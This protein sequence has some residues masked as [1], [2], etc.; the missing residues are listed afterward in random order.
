MDNLM[1]KNLQPESEADRQLDQTLAALNAV[2]PPARLEQ[3]VHARL[4][5]EMRTPQQ[6][7]YR[8]ALAA[9]WTWPRAAFAATAFAAGVATATF[10]LPNLRPAAYHGAPAAPATSV[11]GSGGSTQPSGMPAPA[12]VK[13]SDVHPAFTARPGGRVAAVNAAGTVASARSLKQH[14]DTQLAANK[15]QRKSSEAKLTKPTAP[16]SGSTEQA[17]PAGTAQPENQ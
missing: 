6:Q 4:A 9:A 7:G 1:G 12:V 14:S 8:A 3:R 15:A 11:A 2:V 10:L 17:A 13:Q 16:L 5:N